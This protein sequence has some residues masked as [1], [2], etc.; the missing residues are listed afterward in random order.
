LENP[1]AG[2]RF[3][4]FINR[5]NLPFGKY[6]TPE[7]PGGEGA[8][9]GTSK[10]HP[11]WNQA[12]EVWAACSSLC[13]LTGT[14]ER[15]LRELET[16]AEKACAKQKFTAF[17]PCMPDDHAQKYHCGVELLWD[18]L[19]FTGSGYVAVKKS[20]EDIKLR[21]PADAI[22]EM[23]KSVRQLDKV[24]AQMLNTERAII[25]QGTQITGQTADATALWKAMENLCREWDTL[26]KLPDVIQ[27]RIEMIFKDG[28]Y[29]PGWKPQGEFYPVEGWKQSRKAKAEKGK[30][31]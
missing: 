27:D 24:Q 8:W 2:A 1:D 18:I 10:T 31:S 25:N 22:A 6:G 5:H 30:G 28:E 13:N 11:V 23:S 19:R 15:L 26:I 29:V 20:V 14:V 12:A 21:S 16:V 9:L 17:L 7:V 3:R 4:E